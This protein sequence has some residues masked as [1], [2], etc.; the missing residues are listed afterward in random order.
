MLY[1]ILPGNSFCFVHVVL[2]GMKM[3]SRLFPALRYSLQVTVTNREFAHRR[4]IL[5]GSSIGKYNVPS[6]LFY[7]R[8]A[9]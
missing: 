6:A 3:R 4:V 1:L 9:S 7:Q 8:E 5:L 2:A